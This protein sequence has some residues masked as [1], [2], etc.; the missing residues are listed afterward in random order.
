MDP[1][2]ND[3]REF[4]PPGR[5]EVPPGLVRILEGIGDAFFTLDRDW[6]FTSL[7]PNALRHARRSAGRG[8]VP[9]PLLGRS[10]WEAFP[11][12]LGTVIEREYRRALAEQVLVR[13]ETP[14]V[15]TSGVVPGRWFEVY[16]LPAPEGLTVYSR[17]I[18]ARRQAEER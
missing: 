6:R 18:S 13:F 17:D 10:I 9:P 5:P 3:D 2:G 11:E 7:S 12:L 16:A 1:Q 14:G 15:G 8:G 4:A